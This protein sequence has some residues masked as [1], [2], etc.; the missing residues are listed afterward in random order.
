MEAPN[1]DSAASEEE[2]TEVVKAMDQQ[3]IQRLLQ[4]DDLKEIEV[5]SLQKVELLQE[6]L[7]V[8]SLQCPICMDMADQAQIISQCGH[9]LCRECLTSMYHWISCC[10]TRKYLHGCFVI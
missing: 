9:I 3:V 1:I 6:W 10:I 7:M 5:C 2:R 4:S 8:T